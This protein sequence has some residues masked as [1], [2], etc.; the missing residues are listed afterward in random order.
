MKVDSAWTVRYRS[1]VGV[2][3][4]CTLSEVAGI[5]FEHCPQ[6]RERHAFRGSTSKRGWYYFATTEQLKWCQS[7][8]EMRVLRLLDHDPDVV[9][10]AV[11]PFLLHY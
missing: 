4:E 3:A 8:F 7:R 2:W 5:A 11:Q 6:V 9:A 10:V 1:S